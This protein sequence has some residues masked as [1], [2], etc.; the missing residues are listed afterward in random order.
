MAAL[1]DTRF[2]IRA[3]VLA[4]A[5]GLAWVPLLI[6]SLLG[7]SSLDQA[8]DTATQS[9]T[10]ALQIQAEANL[11]KRAADKAALYNATL[12]TVQQQVEGV[13]AYAKVLLATDAP[14]ASAPG[15]VWFS[16]GGLTPEDNREFALSVGRARQFI[17]LLRSTVQQNPLISLG[18][19]GLED[20]GVVAFDH[21]IVDVINA[22]SPFDPRK[23]S[24]YIAARD[25]KRTV[26]VA[27]Y[28][29]ANTKKL[30]T[31]CA[32]PLYD[33]SGTFVGVIGF[34]LLLDTIQQDILKLDLG[35]Q[36]TP[37]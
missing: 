1:R 20:G 7:L 25:A 2:S 11:A 22:I 34:D 29:D 8:R 24:W 35:N 23:R 28:I 14:P 36:A 19:V 9:V 13:S 15:R 4:L 16:P 6:V 17:P 30:T 32:T 31:T 10:A 33:A 12:N 18:Y 37:F 27:T 3:K 26:W 21:D 5:L